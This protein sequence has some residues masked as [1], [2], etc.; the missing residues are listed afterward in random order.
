MLTRNRWTVW[1]AASLT[2]AALVAGNAPTNAT[3]KA[4]PG[5]ISLELNRIAGVQSGCQLSFVARNNLEQSI[6]RASFE[7]A[8]F[9]SDGLLQRLTAL[10]FRDLPA[11]KTKIRQFLL[12]DM[13]CDTLGRIVVNDEAACEGAPKG[14]CYGGLATSNRTNIQFG[15]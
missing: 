1:Y 15:D 13:K 7:F 2:L 8:F 12:P 9:G 14:S 4:E 3:D 11:G 6:T 10:D 5:A